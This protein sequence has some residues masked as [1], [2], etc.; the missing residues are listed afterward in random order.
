MLTK[1][2]IQQI[3]E[4]SFNV[5]SC[6]VIDESHKH[7]GHAEAQKGGGGHYELHIVSSDFEG[8]SPVQRHRMINTVLKDLF[9]THIHALAIKAKIPTKI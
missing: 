7:A 2:K 5:T 3:L 6:E 4:Q 9:G 8:K 1:D